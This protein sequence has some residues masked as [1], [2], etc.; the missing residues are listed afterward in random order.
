MVRKNT[1]EQ[2]HLCESKPV[3]KVAESLSVPTQ[4]VMCVCVS[5]QIA[6]T[7]PLVSE[8]QELS[9]L[10]KEYAEDDMVYQLKIKVGGLTHL[11]LRLRSPCIRFTAVPTAA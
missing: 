4:T 3:V 5:V 11:R 1:V 2:K 8:R 6:N 9:V 10:Q 7:N